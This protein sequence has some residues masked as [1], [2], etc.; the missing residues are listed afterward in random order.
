MKSFPVFEHIV[1]SLLKR[2]TA[3]AAAAVP[4]FCT[5]NV[6]VQHMEHLS[7]HHCLANKRYTQTIR[8]HFLRVPEKDVIHNSNIDM[9]ECCTGFNGTFYSHFIWKAFSSMRTMLQFSVWWNQVKQNV[10][11]K[12]NRSK[13]L[14]EFYCSFFLI[15]F[16][17]SYFTVEVSFFL[18]C[19][20]SEE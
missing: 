19:L 1:V 6:L 20:K 4:Q 9:N 16:L 13:L 2:V 15:F 11:W 5:W 3:T 12:S 14:V 7:I 18:H 10:Q 17:T 8:H